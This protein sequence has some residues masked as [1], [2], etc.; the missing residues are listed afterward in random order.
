[1][2]NQLQVAKV[3]YNQGDGNDQAI[4]FDI[5]VGYDE[6]IYVHQ[7]N[8]SILPD[9][10]ESIFAY[11]WYLD[12]RDAR[13]TD[14]PINSTAQSVKES[15]ILARGTIAY[16]VGTSADG[17]G[18]LSNELKFPE[19]YQLVRS[20]S[21]V[22]NNTAGGGESGVILADLYYTKAKVSK[23]T[24]SKLLKYWFAGNSRGHR[25]SGRAIS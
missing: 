3:R 5:G 21:L 8:L 11:F 24:I 2:K 6:V 18:N 14:V 17:Y 10:S 19:P 7:I 12:Q 23:D 13:N 20:P 4:P 1:M 15:S 25:E 22:I 9:Y 16:R